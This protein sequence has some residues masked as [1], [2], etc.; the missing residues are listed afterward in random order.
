[1]WRVIAHFMGNIGR[2]GRRWV[3]AVS[4]WWRRRCFWGEG[5]TV[6]LPDGRNLNHEIL[7]AG[8]A[9]WYRKYARGD[10]RAQALESDARRNRRGL[11]AAADPEPPWGWRKQDHVRSRSDPHR[12]EPR[13][14]IR[15]RGR[16]RR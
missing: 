4:G 3:S 8:L 2:E 11:W 12:S 10:L 6:M 15:S 13:I 16:S 5:V 7:A 9:W 14:R 1:M